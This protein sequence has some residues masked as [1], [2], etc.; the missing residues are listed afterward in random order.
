MS[1]P[2]NFNISYYKGDLYQFV[3]RPKTSAGD[4]FPISSSTHTPFFYISTSR[5][6]P[7]ENTI[8]AAASI[9]GGNITATIFPSEGNQLSPGTQYFYDV[10]VQKNTDPDE[11][12]TLL[13][14]TVSVTGDITEPIS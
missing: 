7:A 13:T 6:G 9:D 14:G 12:F 4:P 3:I 8:V 11:I 1:F 10:S 5:N 2:A